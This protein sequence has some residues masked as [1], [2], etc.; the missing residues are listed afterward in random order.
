MVCPEQD[1]GSDPGALGFFI[2]QID[3]PSYNGQYQG[4]DVSAN[5]ICTLRVLRL[6]LDEKIICNLKMK[7][8]ICNK[9]KHKGL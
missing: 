7:V 9:C 3:I 4:N 6:V 2:G 5:K 8:E 1:T